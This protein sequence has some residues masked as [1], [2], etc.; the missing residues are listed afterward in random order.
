MNYLQKG[1][2]YFVMIDNNAC[3]VC[4]EICNGAY[5]SNTLSALPYT[6]TLPDDG[7]KHNLIRVYQLGAA[8]QGAFIPST[9]TV[10]FFIGKFGTK[11]TISQYQINGNEC[12]VLKSDL[13]GFFK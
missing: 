8:S 4:N 11:F 13:E 12:T 9:S 7:L 5:I 2:S 3:P 10:G 1:G 6:F